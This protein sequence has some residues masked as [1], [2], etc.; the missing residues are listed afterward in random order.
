MDDRVIDILVKPPRAGSIVATDMNYFVNGA[1]TQVLKMIPDKAKLEFYSEVTVQ[2]P[3]SGKV[4][5]PL[6]SSTYKSYN[7]WEWVKHVADQIY[8]AIQSNLD[9]R[10]QDLNLLFRFFTQPSGG[11][12][13]ATQNRDLESRT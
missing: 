13:A 1:L 8:A 4:Y 2:R 10:M 3:T 5:L 11:G 12:G 7:V 6:V 9:I